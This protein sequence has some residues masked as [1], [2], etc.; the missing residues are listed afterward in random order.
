MKG[1][2]T[3]NVTEVVYTTNKGPFAGLIPSGILGISSEYPELEAYINQHL[4]PSKKAAFYK[5]RSQCIVDD[6]V[7]FAFQDIFSYFDNGQQALQDPIPQ[8]VIRDGGVMGLHGVPRMP[9]YAYKGVQDEIS[10]V[11]D[12]DALINKLCSEGAQI[13]YVRDE[14]TEHLS[15]IPIGS[16]G[17]LEFLVQ[18]FAGIPAKPGCSTRTEFNE[19]LDPANAP[20]YGEIIYDDFKLLLD[21]PV[22]PAAIGFN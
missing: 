10:V 20:V 16:A 7:Q 11:A 8:A 3:P 2:L 22:G 12:T 5:A 21:Q 18:R 15:E 14:T 1:G 9:I 19:G 17:G 6:A 13:E 4:I